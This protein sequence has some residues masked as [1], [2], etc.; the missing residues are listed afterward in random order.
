MTEILTE[1]LTDID[2]LWLIQCLVAIDS[3]LVCGWFNDWFN[4]LIDSMI[5]C[6]WLIDWLIDWVI[7]SMI[8]CE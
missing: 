6:D 1:I 4:D 3:M 5:D 8:D 2:W 7:D